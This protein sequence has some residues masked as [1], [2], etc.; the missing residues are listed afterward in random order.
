MSDSDKIDA[1]NSAG[2]PFVNIN[3]RKNSILLSLIHHTGMTDMTQNITAYYQHYIIQ[4]NTYITVSTLDRELN[5][6]FRSR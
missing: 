4:Q 5:S 1:E 2:F 3:T 6:F